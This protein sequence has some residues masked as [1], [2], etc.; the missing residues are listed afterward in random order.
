LERVVFLPAAQPPHKPDQILAGAADRIA[1]LELALRGHDDWI[2]D[3]LELQRPGP[4]YT[5]DT[6][7]QVRER[8][9]LH[10]NAR[11]YLILGSDNLR[12]FAQWKDAASLLQLTEPV[13]VPRETD[14]GPTLERLRAEWAPELAARLEQA[15]V[16]TPPVLVASSDIRTALRCG[17]VARGD[18]P[19]GVQEYIEAR[20]IYGARGRGAPRA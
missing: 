6:L 3:G 11:L 4:S 12:G 13:V 7:R 20:G 5:I 9:R 10:P 8:W 2:V 16:A 18:L 17:D 14:L 1:M 19:D 15:I